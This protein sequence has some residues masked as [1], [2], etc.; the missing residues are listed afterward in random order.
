MPKV[1]S[2]SL[3]SQ[4]VNA[5]RKIQAQIAKAASAE[6]ANKMDPAK[7]AGRLNGKQLS[8]L[9]YYVKVRYTD[10]DRYAP[11]KKKKRS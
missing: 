5:L 10:T 9:R 3:L 2:R 7:L 8:A 4:Q 6:D 1:E 11:A